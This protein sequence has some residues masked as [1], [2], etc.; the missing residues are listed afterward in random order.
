MRRAVQKLGNFPTHNYNRLYEA[1]LESLNA[2]LPAARKAPPD[3]DGETFAGMQRI[4]AI[5]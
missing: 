1:V 4:M 3:M 2:N 5:V